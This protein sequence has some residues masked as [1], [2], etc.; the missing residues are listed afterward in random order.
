LGAL[1]TFRPDPFASSRRDGGDFP[2]Y[3][4]VPPDPGQSGRQS[5]LGD[6]DS[7]A[8]GLF[9]MAVITFLIDGA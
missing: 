5:L 3:R 9:S 8:T 1:S 4:R 6:S 7:V 2:L